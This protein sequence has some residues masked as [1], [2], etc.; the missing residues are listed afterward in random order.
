MDI[1]KPIKRG[2]F[3][4]KFLPIFTIVLL[5][6]RHC[7][8]NNLFANHPKRK[9]ICVIKS[10]K[11]K[12]KSLREQNKPKNPSIYQ[13]EKFIIKNLNK[14]LK[15]LKKVAEYNPSIFKKLLYPVTKLAII[16][17][18]IVGTA[19][20][21]LYDLPFP[22]NPTT[23]CNKMISFFRKKSQI[24]VQVKEIKEKIT[25]AFC[26]GNLPSYLQCT[27]DNPE[28]PKRTFFRLKPNLTPEEKKSY[29]T[30]KL[31]LENLFK[32]PQTYPLDQ[33]EK[34]I[35]ELKEA[36]EIIDKQWQE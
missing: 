9:L 10:N 27:V 16:S 23:L 13:N 1:L 3:M 36:I 29:D 2:I 31:R 15:K 12:P 24:P 32:H 6:A 8:T 18:I 20:Y 26:P 7:T 28:L 34:S 35:Q 4:K 11:K 19:Y 5:L 17:G 22:L 30:D 14:D 21:A 25:F 33:L